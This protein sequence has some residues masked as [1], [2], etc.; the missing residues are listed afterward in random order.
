MSWWSGH[1]FYTEKFSETK[2]KKPTRYCKTETFFVSR[3]LQLY[4]IRY[5]RFVLIKTTNFPY[6]GIPRCYLLFRP[7]TIIIRLNSK[8]IQRLF[9]TGIPGRVCL[10]KNDPRSAE[11]QSHGKRLVCSVCG[12]PVRP[13]SR[14]CTGHV[15]QLHRW[16]RR[17]GRARVYENVTPSLSRILFSG[18]CCGVT[19][20]NNV[21]SG[22]QYAGG[23]AYTY[24]RAV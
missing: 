20:D 12:R 10:T 14:A 18:W 19:L 21:P 2:Y 22:V 13:R 1:I 16:S 17:L 3:L 11:N 6:R 5:D 7:Y 24:V 4:R 15:R 9:M 8:K 23:Y